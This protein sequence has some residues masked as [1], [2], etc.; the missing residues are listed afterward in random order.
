[1]NRCSCRSVAVEVGFEPTEG[2]PP[3]TLSSTAHHRS[4]PSASVRDQRG[5]AAAD[6]GERPRTGVNETNS[7]TTGWRA[8]M[9]DLP[10]AAVG[11]GS[12]CGCRA[13]AGV[14]AAVGPVFVA[15]G[16]VLG[17]GGDLGL[18]VF[19]FGRA[20][21]GFGLGAWCAAGLPHAFH[22]QGDERGGD[23]QDHRSG[24]DRYH[25]PQRQVGGRCGRWGRRDRS[26]G[27]LRREPARRGGG[28]AD[29]WG[30]EDRQCAQRCEGPAGSGDAAS[31]GARLRWCWSVVHL[32]DSFGC[33][34]GCSLVACCAH[35]QCSAG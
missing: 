11:V 28:K 12:L 22:G 10:A 17:A 7:E 2:L 19:G 23:G 29:L 33:L 1:M 4:P 5:Q 13:A 3:H 6:A 16:R 27:R 21:A 18:R 25:S 34:G 9:T 14:S 20:G 35:R 32:G 24:H 8:R 30:Q 26:A 31:C 15:A